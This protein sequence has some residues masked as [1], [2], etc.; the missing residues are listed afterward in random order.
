MSIFSKKRPTIEKMANKLYRRYLKAP[1]EDQEWFK[2]LTLEQLCS[3]HLSLG[4]QI[5]NE[6]RL[7]E[8]SWDKKI[9]NGIDTSPE[10]PDAVSQRVIKEVWIKVNT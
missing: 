5:R 3:T 9:V 8:Y 7:W 2:S 4:T 1:I 10:H 6:F